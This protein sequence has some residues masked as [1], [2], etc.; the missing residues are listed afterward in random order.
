MLEQRLSED[1][2][3]ALKAGEKLR[4]STLRSLKSALIYA[5]VAP[6]AQPLDDA[7]VAALFE[8]EAKKRKESYEAFKNAGRTESAAQEL[9]E[10][11][12][13]E[14]Y[15]PKALSEQEIK[16]LVEA[17][18]VELNATGPQ[19]MGAV[20]VHIKSQNSARIDG[21]LLSKLVR[22]RLAHGNIA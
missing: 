13:I 15:L 1:M 22:E 20:M 17:T 8:K 19:A 12:I 6:G 18:V 16:D 7:A 9:E 5:N 3:T 2:K 10:L 4:L 14:Q 11:K 21:A